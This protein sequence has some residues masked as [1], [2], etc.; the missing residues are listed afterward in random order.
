[1][2]LS[3]LT[4]LLINQQDTLVPHIE[5]RA[6]RYSMR[7]YVMAQRVAIFGDMT[8]WNVRKVSEYLRPRRG[9]TLAED[10][11]IP[12]TQVERVR[13]AE[14]EPV[15]VGDRHR[16]SDRRAETDL[17]NVV[18]DTIE[19]LGQ[20]IGD[21][22]EADFMQTAINTFSGGAIDQSANN[23]DLQ[24]P[25]DVQFEFR[26]RA[27]RGQ[28]YHVIHPFQARSVMKDL[29]TFNAVGTN[30]D[31]RN[32]AIAGWNVPAFD[33]LNIAISDFLP[34]NVPHYIDVGGDGGT[35]RLQVG[36]GYT[37]GENITATIDW[38][39][40][41]ATVAT[42]IQTALNAL[43]MSSFYSGAGTWT[44]TH[45]STITGGERYDVVPPADLWLD[46]EQELRVAVDYTGTPTLE[47]QK[48]A[49]DLLTN[50]TLADDVDGNA[51]GVIVHEQAG[52]TARS[53]MFFR[54]ALVYDVRKPV[55]AY[56]ELVNQGRTAEYSAYEVYGIGKWRSEHGMT[57]ETL[58]ESALALA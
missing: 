44:V 34:R 4:K 21:R 3:A 17:E 24:Y 9:Q 51:Q 35:F 28:L 40:T 33:G 7:R 49:Y 43:D 37:V 16:I 55:T 38:N 22:K 8:G 5:E 1:M 29:I 46:G 14:I 32:Q 15:E 26:K 41:P 58:A 25:V 57:I 42:N 12:D 36:V 50:P 31:F 53:L 48:S 19:F 20:A 52:A 39:A 6:L 56:F 18:S 11:A 47:G 10:T 30:L 13:K 45:D 27:R 2:A 54:D 23:Y